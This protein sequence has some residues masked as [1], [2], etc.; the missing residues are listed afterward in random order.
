MN[1]YKIKVASDEY[2]ELCFANVYASDFM[3]DQPRAVP[4]KSSWR[5]VEFRYTRPDTEGYQANAIDSDFISLNGD[6]G[7]SAATA[8]R[9]SEWLSPYGELLPVRVVDDGSTA[10]WFHCTRLIDALDEQNSIG[11]IEDD[12]RM[13]NPSL[14]VFFPDKIKDSL[15]FVIPQLGTSVYCTD[16][17]KTIV[18]ESGLTGLSFVL[19]WSDEPKGIAQIEV[20]KQKAGYLKG[21]KER[22]LKK[23]AELEAAGKRNS[24]L[25]K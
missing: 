12:G 3:R 1:V 17:L 5:L 23:R 20:W 24:G 18:E 9:T 22:M 6:L 10:Y 14:F 7:M 25:A 11:T 4:F 19:E 15:V 13:R 21:I 16:R 8:E 2:K